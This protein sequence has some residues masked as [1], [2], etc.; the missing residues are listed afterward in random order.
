MKN[1][2]AAVIGCGRI[3]IEENLFAKNLYPWTHAGG[4]ANHPRTKL[5]VLVDRNPSR[6]KIANKYYPSIPT[7][8]NLEEA[9]EKT[10]PDI[11]SIATPTTTH[12]EV[13]R[14][15]TLFDC[16][17]AIVCEKPIAMDSL[18]AL[19]MIDICKRRKI[20]FLVNHS[21]R[22]DPIFREALAWIK[23]VGPIVQGSAYYTRGIYNNGTHLIDLLNLYLGALKNVVGFVNRET[24][25]WDDLEND[26]NI[27]GILFFKNGA[28][29]TIQS[30]DANNFSI[31]GIDLYGK[32]GLV[33][34]SDNG[35]KIEYFNVNDSS[36]FPGRK[37]LDRNPKVFKV[38]KSMILS[39]VDNVVNCLDGKDV[40]LGSGN[41]ALIALKSI[42]AL[43]LSAK[44]SDKTIVSFK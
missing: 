36:E 41:D 10:K 1:Y 7:F 40:P 22:F 26:L 33:R 15:V 43:E 11:V 2:K 39:M 6:L 12:F 16:V 38:E 8:I 3:G 19:E 30:L 20:I 29:I 37:E 21:R 5:V 25:D 14:A 28:R 4:Y 34:I 32:N 9:I 44:S 18:D 27:D 17:K 42:K 31:F 13:V 23:Q 24:E 35:F